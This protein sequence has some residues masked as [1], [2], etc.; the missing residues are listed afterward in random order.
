[1]KKVFI[2]FVI[3]ILLIVICIFAMNIFKKRPFNQTRPKRYTVK[4]DGDEY[5]F[6]VIKYAPP[7]FHTKLLKNREEADCSTPE[8]THLA[9][10][11]AIGRD[12]QWRLSLYDDSFKEYVLKV[13]KELNGKFLHED[14]K[15]K[16]LPTDLTKTD[17]YSKFIYKLETEVKGKRYAILHM[18]EVWQEEGKEK[19]S[20]SFIVFVKQKDIWLR[21][22]L[23]DD[24]P[25][26]DLVGL[27]SYE[28]LQKILKKG[29]WSD[30]IKHKE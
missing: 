26:A 2:S 10:E 8:G 7:Y 9:L 18:K 17:W 15:G 14:L 29:T 6:I 25:L 3:F 16:P 21:T 27:N 5:S 23:L 24:H 1:M 20:A 30:P 4:I 22:K 13:D 12:T 28:E 19:E 11:S